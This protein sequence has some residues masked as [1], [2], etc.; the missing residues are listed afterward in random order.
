MTKAVLTLA[1]GLMLGALSFAT[2]GAAQVAIEQISPTLSVSQSGSHNS[3]LVE[4]F[5][6]HAGDITQVGDRNQAMMISRAPGSRQTISQH[7]S[8]NLGVQLSVGFDNTAVMTQGSTLAQG[9][10]NMALQ[11][12]IGARNAARIT[13]NGSGNAAAQIQT[14]ALSFNQARAVASNLTSDLREGRAA[15]RV[16]ELSG[17]GFGVGNS[18]ELTQNGDDN[19]AVMIQA[20][21]HNQMNI[22]QN[23][24]AANVYVQL[25]NGLQRTA[26][27]EQHAGANGVTPITIIQ[28]R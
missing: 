17:L 25:G 10:G 22:T 3:S 12:Q 16:Q 14:G 1:S 11:A 19:L 9:S 24:G 8:D 28:S 20:G 2:P 18:A 21:D 6:A 7:G 4:V 26:M 27:V 5:G 23:G 13:Q 15:S